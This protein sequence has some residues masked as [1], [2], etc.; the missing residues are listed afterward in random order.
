MTDPSARSCVNHEWIVARV[1][2]TEVDGSLFGGR[3]V[4]QEER[5]RF[6]VRV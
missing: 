1:G 3:I 6:A 4:T 2:E 5:G